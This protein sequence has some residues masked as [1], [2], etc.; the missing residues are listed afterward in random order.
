MAGRASL[1]SPLKASCNRKFGQWHQSFPAHGVLSEQGRNCR[2]LVT[3]ACAVGN[4]VLSLIRPTM[5]DPGWGQSSKLEKALLQRASWSRFVT[6]S[7]PRDI[8][9]RLLLNRKWAALCFQ[10]SPGPPGG[11]RDFVGGDFFWRRSGQT[12]S[13]HARLPVW[14]PE[15]RQ[16]WSALMRQVQRASARRDATRLARRTRHGL[17]RLSKPE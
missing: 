17:W 11:V 13:A 8:R 16:W 12:A 7:L 2:Y 3:E 9:E 5:G 1:H 15:G 14:P 6:C 10:E 4:S